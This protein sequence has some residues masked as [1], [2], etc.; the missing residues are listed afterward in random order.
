VSTALATI[1]SDIKLQDAEVVRAQLL[2]Q[3]KS[4]AADERGGKFASV[5][6]AQASGTE[7]AT[8]YPR[9][10]STLPWGGVDLVCC[11]GV[12]G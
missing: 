3:I 8:L 1:I 12:E 5:N 11:T 4:A 9:Q 7:P 6:K 2:A 10:P